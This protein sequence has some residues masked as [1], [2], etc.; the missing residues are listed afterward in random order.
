MFKEYFFLVQC[1][2]EF[3]QDVWSLVWVWVVVGVGGG[4]G[5]KPEKR[6]ACFCL[7]LKTRCCS[8]TGT[9]VVQVL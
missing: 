8:G 2:K 4:A 3:C 5:Q 9:V 6:F 1:F 7:L